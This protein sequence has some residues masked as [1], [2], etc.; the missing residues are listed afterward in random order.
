M[1][2]RTDFPEIVVLI[3][4][5]RFEDAFRREGERLEKS[6]V[7]VLAMTFFAHADGVNVSPHE[8]EI[9]RRVDRARIDLGDRVHVINCETHVCRVCNKACLTFYDPNGGY[10]TSVC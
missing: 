4:S 2:L 8:R 9:L 7:L 1:S 10:H 5:S 6:G 3:G